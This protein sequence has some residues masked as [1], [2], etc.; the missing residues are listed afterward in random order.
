MKLTITLPPTCDGFSISD[1]LKDELLIPRKVRH[2]LRTRK[3]VLVNGTNQPFHTLL[4]SGDVLE[5]EFLDSDYP[6]PHLLDADSSSLV[7]L[8]EDEHLI[9]VDKPAG[10]KTH[11]NEPTEN[12][13]LINQVGGYLK[14]KKQIPYVVHRLDKETSG[15][16]LFAKNP[17]ILPILGRMLEKKDIHRIYQAQVKGHF[18]EKEFTINRPIGRHRHDRRMRVIDE[19]NGQEAITHVTV[20]KETSTTSD[21]EVILDT[22]RTHQIRVHLASLKHPILGDPL[23]NLDAK[24]QPLALRATELFFVHPFTKEQIHVISPKNLF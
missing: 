24:K 8:Y 4:R 23:Y 6:T 9:I 3:N 15:L 13:T 18:K 2:F 20:K 12:G 5:L 19:K 7:V 22:G 21:L 14:D 10:V 11:P 17:V 16:V 1:Y